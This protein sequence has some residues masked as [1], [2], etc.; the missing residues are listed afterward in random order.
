MMRQLPSEEF[1]RFFNELAEIAS[2]ARKGEAEVTLQQKLEEAG[3]KMELPESLGEEIVPL[4]TT[5]PRELRR[6]PHNCGP[7]GLCGLCAACA[8]LDAAAAG[9]AAAAIWHILD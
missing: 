9:A 8:E 4:L 7:C 5:P 2:G 6:I 1:K 3:I